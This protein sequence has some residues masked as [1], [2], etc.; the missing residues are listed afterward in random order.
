MSEQEAAAVIASF[1][2]NGMAAWLVT[3]GCVVVGLFC[4]AYQ[5]HKVRK[6]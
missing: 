2:N 3:V 1:A 5:C 4:A 6:R